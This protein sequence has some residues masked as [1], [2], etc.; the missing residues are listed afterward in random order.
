ME[1]R[2][3]YSIILP[4]QNQ[5]ISLPSVP[6][7]FPAVTRTQASTSAQ[8]ST[9]VIADHIYDYVELD[10]PERNSSEVWFAL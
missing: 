2:A 8:S 6:D 7:H 10:Y 3:K 9:H 1:A 5:A 4:R